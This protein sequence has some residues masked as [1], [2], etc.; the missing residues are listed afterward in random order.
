VTAAQ[1]EELDAPQAEEVLRA[2][3]EVLALAGYDPGSALLVASHVEVDV[4]SAIDLIE[5]GCPPDVAVRIVL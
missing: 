5:R 2:R 3:F 4:E 1:F